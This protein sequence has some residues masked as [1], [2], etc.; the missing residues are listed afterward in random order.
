MWNLPRSSPAWRG[1]QSREAMSV[2]TLKPCAR[3]SGYSSV[4]RPP[5]RI[6]W[7]S[8]DRT[9]DNAKL[10][11]PNF[12]GSCESN[13][14]DKMTSVHRPLLCVVGARKCSLRLCVRL[15]WPHNYTARLECRG[16][17]LYLQSALL[18]PS[19]LYNRRGS[20]CLWFYICMLHNRTDF[21]RKDSAHC[22]LN[23][24]LRLI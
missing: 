12:Q 6:M 1:L 20:A 23:N 8:P 11:L 15:A 24:Y 7:A 17:S 18:R 13:T 14:Q 9:F 2:R 21:R 5:P 10:R 3:A 19:A 16:P 4:L 22:D